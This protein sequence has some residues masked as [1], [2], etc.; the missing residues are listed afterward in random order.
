M[1]LWAIKVKIKLII[2]IIGVLTMTTKA[3]LKQMIVDEWVEKHG[4]TQIDDGVFAL[5][6]DD[7]FVDA[8]KKAW[9]QLRDTH[10]G[11][12]W[13]NN[14]MREFKTNRYNKLKVYG[15]NEN[16]FTGTLFANVLFVRGEPET[17]A[18]D[19]ESS[20]DGVGTSSV[21]S[22]DDRYSSIRIIKKGE[23]NTYG[24]LPLR[25]E[26]AHE[27]IHAQR[28][29][30]GITSNDT[31]LDEMQVIKGMTDAEYKAAK[32]LRESRESNEGRLFPDQDK[33]L[34]ETDMFIAMGITPRTRHNDGARGVF[35]N[36]PDDSY[37]PL[38]IEGLP[39]GRVEYQHPVPR[40]R[41]MT[42]MEALENPEEYMSRCE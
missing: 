4:V 42:R 36:D 19:E 32:I 12:V 38:I 3:D 26:M 35:R 22:L 24:V 17:L 13:R 39:S 40:Y 1:T 10:I 37:V 33:I 27:G 16:G 8:I 21:I 25:A 29:L 15:T 14:L 7:H 2:L 18:W 28:N 6:E 11:E 5:N 23:P 34:S 30:L 31:W 20:H 41:R 9:Q